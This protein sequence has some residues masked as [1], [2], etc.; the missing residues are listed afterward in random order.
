MPTSLYWNSRTRINLPYLPYFSNCKG[1]GN[2]IP[3]WSLMEQHHVCE[4]IENFDT[5][6]MAEF[7]FGARPRAD[8][9]EEVLINCVYEEVFVGQQPLSRWFR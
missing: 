4:L 3:F 5:R 7:T 1:Y 6:W 2:F 8:S 9:C